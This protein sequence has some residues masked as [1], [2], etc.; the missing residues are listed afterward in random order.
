MKKRTIV[1]ISVITIVCLAFAIYCVNGVLNP[2]DADKKPNS[3]QFAILTTTDMHGKVWD[4][5]LLTGKQTPGNYLA[6]STVINRINDN[7]KKRYY[8][9][10]NGDSY[11]GTDMATFPLKQSV[12]DKYHKVSPVAIALEFMGYSGFGLGNH[13]FNY[14]WNIMKNTYTHLESGGIDLT[15]ANIYD[16]TTGKRVFKPYDLKTTEIDGKN[17]TLVNIALENTDV[18]KWDSEENYPNLI[19][20]SP[21][22]ENADLAYEVNKVKKEMNDNGVHYDFLMVS[23]H[24]GFVSENAKFDPNKD[25]AGEFEKE[26][27]IPLSYL[28]NT[29]NQV[30]RTIRNTEGIDMFVAGHDHTTFLSNKKFKNKSGQD[31]L[32]VNGGGKDIT[33]SVFNANFNNKTNKFEVSLDW[34]KNLD[35]SK[36][37]SDERLKGAIYTYSRESINYIERFIG[38]LRGNFDGG[39][40]LDIGDYITRQTDTEDLVMRGCMWSN[41]ELLKPLYQNMDALNKKLTELGRPVITDSNEVKCDL[42]ICNT[43]HV[44]ENPHDGQFKVKDLFKLYKYSNTM[45]TLPMTGQEIK[46][47]LE[48]NASERLTEDGGYKGDKY[49]YCLAYGLNFTYDMTRPVGNRVIIEG[50]TNGR[51][52]NL[53]HT[54]IVSTNNYITGNQANKSMGK[55]SY[56]LNLI[57]DHE[58]DE[59]IVDGIK[60]Y[61][62]YLQS[63]DNAIYNTAN[64]DKNGEVASHWNV[65][66]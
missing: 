33:E 43:G 11:Q 4:E 36:Y 37:P 41:N 35:L 31:V 34:S 66:K 22:N 10:D 27:Q 14:P 44:G 51:E 12:F 8:V 55:F 2:L 25:Y 6:V 15:C 7:F 21:E 5:D 50:L 56:D 28:Q 49:S 29:E 3:N 64:C 46:D 62:E 13:E 59:L 52:F 26:T 61:L 16:K 54:Y 23:M 48:Y 9:F 30:Y 24:S 18:P 58:G 40:D 20:H 57:K 1:L 47:V 32:V 17:F 19:F 65:I 45:V 63:K 38:T 60:A 42:C 53:G 39:E